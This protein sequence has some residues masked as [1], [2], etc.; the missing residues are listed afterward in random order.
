MA[1]LQHYK[2]LTD[3]QV[4]ESRR[5]HGANV[6]TPP[7]REPLWRKFLKKFSD[8]LIVILL[9]AGILS[10]GISF[11]EYLGLHEGRVVFFE[12]VGIFIA[13][14][15]ATGLAFLFEYKADKEFEL[16]NQVNDDEPVQVFRNGMWH[17]ISKREVVVGDIVVV[18]ELHAHGATVL[19][20]RKAV[21]LEDELAESLVLRHEVVRHDSVDERA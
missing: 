4:L 14:L 5:L 3:Q 8:P 13:I 16:L 7:Q 17:Q 2:G 10:I 1:K 20:E 19:A 18:E 12:P 9:V 15:L 11:Y 6:L 21:L